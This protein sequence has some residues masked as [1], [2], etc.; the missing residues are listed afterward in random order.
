MTEKLAFERG[1]MGRISTTGQGIL[2]QIVDVVESD[3]VDA[4]QNLKHPRWFA[5]QEHHDGGF[6]GRTA[7]LDAGNF[8]DDNGSVQGKRQDGSDPI[9]DLVQSERRNVLLSPERIDLDGRGVPVRRGDTVLESLSDLV[10]VQ[11]APDEYQAIDSLL[12]GRP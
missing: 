1:Q 4:R 3:L 8:F 11:F 12:I 7:G 5:L 6:D 2:D 10:A 9:A